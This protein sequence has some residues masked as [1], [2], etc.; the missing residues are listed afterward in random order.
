VKLGMVAVLLYAQTLGLIALG[1]PWAAVATSAL[2][3][4]ALLVR[5]VLE[6]KGH[7]ATLEDAKD[8]ADAGEAL[9]RRLVALEAVVES[10]KRQHALS[11][12]G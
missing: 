7:A 2:A 5:M 6:V 1:N 12:L 9:E 8:A 3:L 11:R 10:Q 4:V